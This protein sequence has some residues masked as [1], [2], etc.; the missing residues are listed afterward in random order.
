VVVPAP[1]VGTPHILH[2][3]D[4]ALVS[5]NIALKVEGAAIGHLQSCFTHTP[6]PAL[7]NKKIDLN[8]ESPIERG[9]PNGC[10][11][12]RAKPLPITRQSIEKANLA[13]SRAPARGFKENP[14]LRSGGVVAALPNATCPLLTQ[15][16]R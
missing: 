2:E 9:T 10:S 4:G 1:D 12:A 14:R 8:R 5:K 7:F 13:L 3:V 6:A 16:G 11:V 15:S